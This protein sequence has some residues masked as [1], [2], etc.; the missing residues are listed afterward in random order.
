[1]VAEMSKIVLLEKVYVLTRCFQGVSWAW[2]WEIVKLVFSR[3]L[4]AEP[5]SNGANTLTPVLSKEY[6]TCIILRLEK[7]KRTRDVET[8]TRGW[9]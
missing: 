4:D 3:K 8:D 7:E 5:K 2:M 6:A 9:Y 1:M